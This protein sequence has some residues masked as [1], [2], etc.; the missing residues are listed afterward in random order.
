MFAQELSQL[1]RHRR[2]FEH[3]VAT[4]PWTAT[5]CPMRSSNDENFSFPTSAVR[6]KKTHLSRFS[7]S[8]GKEQIR[9]RSLLRDSLKIPSRSP[10]ATIVQLRCWGKASKEA[11]WPMAAKTCLRTS[12]L[13]PGSFL[14]RSWN[15]N[16]LRPVTSRN[17]SAGDARP[18]SAQRTAI[19][20]HSRRLKPASFVIAGIRLVH[21]SAAMATERKLCDGIVLDRTPTK[22]IALVA[23]G[24]LET[25]VRPDR[26]VARRRRGPGRPTAAPHQR[27]GRSH[28]DRMSKR[29][30]Y[31]E[32]ARLRLGIATLRRR[33]LLDRHEG[34]R[35]RAW[36]CGCR[37]WYGARRRAWRGACRG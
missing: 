4:G 24:R 8:S 27:Q 28:H 9:S 35:R 13:N 26:V 16:S 2:L 20:A 15:G 22:H 32:P 1:G 12:T 34:F 37:G 36:R 3:A 14:S 19:V 17:D 6:M 18:L 29:R 5:S 10:R 7:G 21:F 23:T 11:S 30:R 25:R 33:G 31:C